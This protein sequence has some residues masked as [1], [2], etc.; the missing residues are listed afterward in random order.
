M[1]QSTRNYAQAKLLEHR[2]QAKFKKQK[3]AREYL[4][5]L[6]ANLA[7]QRLQKAFR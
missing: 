5:K 3:I 4:P 2:L 6:V 1:S 7:T